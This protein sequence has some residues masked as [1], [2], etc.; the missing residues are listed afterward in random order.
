M[1]SNSS[2][3]AGPTLI[4]G[5]AI[6]VVAVRGFRPTFPDLRVAI[7][8]G[9]AYVALVFPVDLLLEVNYGYLGQA[10]PN[11][12]TILDWLGPWPWRVVAMMALGV[13]VMVLLYLPWYRSGPRR[14]A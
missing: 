14:P 11:Q 4:V 6:Y 2:T 5:V 9:L 13:G 3:P 8:A 7:G 1:R 12:P 10:L